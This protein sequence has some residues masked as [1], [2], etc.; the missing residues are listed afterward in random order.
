MNVL[1]RSNPFMY[2]FASFLF[3]GGWNLSYCWM[4]WKTYTFF[5]KKLNAEKL[6]KIP[7]PF[8]LQSVFLSLWLFF[9]LFTPLCFLRIWNKVLNDWNS[10]LLCSGHCFKYFINLSAKV[11]IEFISWCSILMD[12]ALLLLLQMD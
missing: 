11:N 9:P 5:S 4:F 6:S 2:I 1:G 7:V 3:D 12:C 8:V 10:Y